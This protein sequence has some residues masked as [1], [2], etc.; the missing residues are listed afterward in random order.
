[1]LNQ[2]ISILRSVYET[3]NKQE[4][5]DRMREY[6]TLG[7]LWSPDL[8]DHDKVRDIIIDALEYMEIL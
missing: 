2:T 7:G 6:L 1:M 5:I 4:L 8:M 3:V